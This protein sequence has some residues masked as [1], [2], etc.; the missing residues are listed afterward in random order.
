MFNKMLF[1]FNTVRC[2]IVFY[3]TYSS[4]TKSSLS[5]LSDQKRNIKFFWIIAVILCLIF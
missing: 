1:F 4:K 3:S 5:N 2:Q